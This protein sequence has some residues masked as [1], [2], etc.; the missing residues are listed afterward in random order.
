VDVVIRRSEGD[1]YEMDRLG[2]FLTGEKGV[3]VLG[4]VFTLEIQRRYVDQSCVMTTLSS[5][6]NSL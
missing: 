6:Y 1:V 5:Y 4:G 3:D 2:Q